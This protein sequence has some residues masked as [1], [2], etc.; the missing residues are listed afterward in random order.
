MTFNRKVRRGLV[1]TAALSVVFAAA[2]CGGG[3]G[4]APSGESSS[5]NV[6]WSQQ[7]DIEYWQGK[8]TSHSGWL[9]NTIAAFNKQHPQGKVTLHELPDSADAQRQQMIQNAQ[10]KNPKMAVLS[11]DNVWTAEFA[12]NGYIV[13]P[14]EGAVDTSGFLK[15]TVDS[16]TYF[17]KLYAIPATS[18]GGVL[19]Y[20]TD[21]LKKYNIAKPPTTFDEM[22][23]DCQ[24]IQAG[25]NDPK[26]GCFAG[27][28][29]KYEGLTVNV[30]EAINSAGGVIVGDDGKPNVNTPEAQKGLGT[31]VDFFK[32]GLIP[33]GAITWQEEDGRRAFQAGQLIFHRNWSGMYGQA[34]ATDGSSKVAGKFATAPLPGITVVPGVSSLGGHN[35]GI[36]ASAANKGTALDFI[37]YMTSAET[38]KSQA[39]ATSSAPPLEKLYSD[40]DLVKK[41]PVYPTLLKS[42]QTAK[43]RPKVVNYGDVTLAIQDSTYSA[44]QQPPQLTP[45]QALQQLQSKLETLIK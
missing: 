2:A 20:R 11:V 14:P 45:E 18:D 28:Y 29:N 41:F 15:A 37:K 43:P 27:Q 32:E 9:Q 36:S 34:E 10:I 5:A 26:L 19:Y 22:K 7:G 3:G 24:K 35:Y 39:L 25:E 13:A 21:L 17:G 33:K 30:A 16:G 40:P 6:D 38:Q 31:L 12:A 1:A 4:S 44:L 42:I 8:D 23:A